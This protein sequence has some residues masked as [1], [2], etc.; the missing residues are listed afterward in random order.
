M[1]AFGSVINAAMSLDLTNPI[2]CALDTMDVAEACR[3]GEAVRGSVGGLKIGLEFF[4]ANGPEG[5]RAIVEIGLPVFFDLKLHDIPN[6][7]AG[8]LRAVGS[9]GAALIN[10]HASGGRAMME[11]AAREAA[12]LGDAAPLVLGVTLLTSLDQN[13]LDDIG[14]TR[15]PEEQV[16]ALAQLAQASGLSGVVCASHEIKALRAAMGADFKLVVPGI[17][18]AGADIGDQKRVMTPR[19]AHDLGADILVIGRPITQAPD[20]ARAAAEIA[21]S[22]DLP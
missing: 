11:A 3:I 10:V 14:V 9:L 1:P 22:L 17:R 2:Y 5:A 4:N 8:G 7:V 20:P 21:D 16:V 15:S 13:D 19:E 12:K 18:P 6:T